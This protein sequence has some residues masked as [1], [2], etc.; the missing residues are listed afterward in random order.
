M[1]NEEKKVKIPIIYYVESKPG[2]PVN[3]IPYIE[4]GLD[5]TMPKVLF[6]QEYRETKEY[7]VDPAHGS[8]PVVDMFMHKYVDME[9]VQ[10]AMSPS[11]FDKL[12]IKL[13]MLPLKEARKRGRSVYD[14]VFKNAEH[15]R[16]ELINNQEKR[17]DRA[18]SLGEDLRVKSEKYLQEQRE[19]E[20]ETP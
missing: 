13:G 8:V 20:K 18:F 6:I 12:R 1:P 5:E 4:V 3:P 15:N 9:H 11:Q 2:E 10:K 17:A 19:E 16:Q 14:K 7:E